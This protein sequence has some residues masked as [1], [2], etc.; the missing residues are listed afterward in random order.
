V[1]GRGVLRRER[2]VEAGPDRR[3]LGD[4][5]EWFRRQERQGIPQGDTVGIHDTQ[6][7]G[8]VAVRRLAFT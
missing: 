1:L 2:D 3:D 7:H 6:P 4:R 5:R 8:P